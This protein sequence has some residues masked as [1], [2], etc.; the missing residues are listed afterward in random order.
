MKIKQ[1][2]RNVFETNSSSTHSIS[3][4][5]S[6]GMY[7]TILPDKKGNILLEGGKFGWEEMEYTDSLTKANYCAVDNIYNEDRLNMLK[8]VIKEHTRCNEVIILANKDS[9]DNPCYSYIDHQSA[10]ISSEAFTSKE[11]LKNFIF[12]KN[13]VLF[14][15]NDNH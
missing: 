2:R 4:V 3:I 11:N 8:E 6:E 15:D 13:S 9:Y 1:I 12:G 5:G 7:D 10:G 14:T